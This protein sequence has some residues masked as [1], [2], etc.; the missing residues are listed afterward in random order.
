MARFDDRV[1]VAEEIVLKGQ[2]GVASGKDKQEGNSVRLLQQSKSFA[3]DKTHLNDL[4]V[5][6]AGRMDMHSVQGMA[7][8]SQLGDYFQYLIDQPVNL[9]RQ[10]SALLPIVNKDVE[11]T[12]V[13]IYN[14]AV[15]AKHPLLGLKFKNISGLHLMQGPITVFESSTYAGRP[16]AL[17]LQPNEER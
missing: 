16:S 8:A 6:M 4:A 10:K 7:T 1:K 9:A 13:S 17:D 12:K 11:G 5:E 14:Q 2:E 3:R 15:Q